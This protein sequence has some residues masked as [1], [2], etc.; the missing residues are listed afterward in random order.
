VSGVERDPLVHAVASLRAAISL[1]KAGG[2][3]AA[4]SDRMF[5]QMLVD[6]ERAANRAAEVLTTP[7]QGLDAATI[8]QCAQVALED[9][10]PA[11]G[12]HRADMEFLAET[13][14]NSIAARIRA[15]NAASTTTREEKNDG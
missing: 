5:E 2:K 11:Y 14:R 8:E 7:A 3:K 13:Q 10:T 1:L 9:M 4:G 15:L 12:P 6:Y